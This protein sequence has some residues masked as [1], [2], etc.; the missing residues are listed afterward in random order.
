MANVAIHPAVDNGMKPAKAGF[1]GGTLACLC[2]KDAV[3]S[4]CTAKFATPIR[5]EVGIAAPHPYTNAQAR[6]GAATQMTGK[7]CA[8]L[9]TA[10][11]LCRYPV[12]STAS[13]AIARS[14]VSSGQRRRAGSR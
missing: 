7:V 9:A 5:T 6:T 11:T 12:L 3:T 4:P 8:P 1:A 10:A 13:T 14:T 2:S